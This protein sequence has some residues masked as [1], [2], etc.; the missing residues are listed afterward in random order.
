MIN[1]HIFIISW[2]GQHENAALICHQA[3]T[4]TNKVTLIYSDPNPDLAFDLS[5][6]TIQRPNDLFWGDKFSTCLAQANDDSILV[7]HADCHY[8]DWTKLI[9]SC[10][11]SITNIP[12]IG[13]WSPLIDHVPWSLNT[14]LIAN[15]SDS[16]LKVTARTDAIV[17]YL[18]PPIVRRMKLAKYEANLYGWGIEWMFVCAA[19]T[20]GMIAVI[21]TSLEVKHP[22]N[23]GYPKVE[24]QE[25][26]SEFV[27][28]LFLPE[29]ILGRLLRS[30]IKQRGGFP[31]LPE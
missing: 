14:M 28:Q 8:S 7:V 29:E 27:K 6:K 26:L 2:A 1:I 31:I 12:A 11:R 3:L 16:S 19:Y 25:Q 13:V 4:I 9:R 23:T 22:K 5:C 10:H 30:H 20:H 18:A 15:I 24:A 21:D 17:F